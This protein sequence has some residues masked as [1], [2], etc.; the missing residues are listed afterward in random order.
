M[1]SFKEFWPLYLRAHQHRRTRIGH[2]FATAIA[3]S[4][5]ATSFVLQ[6]IWLTILGIIIGYGIALASHRLGDGSKSLVLVNP[7]WGALADF[8]MCW[9][10][11]TGGLAAQ[12]AQH[13]GPA[14]EQ[15][16]GSMAESPR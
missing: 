15:V 9:L 5:V 16:E 4:T 14:C 10:A 1:T 2:Y 12:L 6:A 13:V 8:K 7:V 11:L 3:L